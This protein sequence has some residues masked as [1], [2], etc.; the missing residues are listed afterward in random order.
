MLKYGKTHK[1]NQ[2]NS[3]SYKNQIHVYIKGVNNQ[4]NKVKLIYD[5]EKNFCQ[6]NVINDI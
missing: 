3:L 6:I 2:F 1:T 5:V 4:I